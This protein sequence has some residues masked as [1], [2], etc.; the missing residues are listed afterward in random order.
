MIG[1]PI[2]IHTTPPLSIRPFHQTPISPP[3]IAIFGAAAY[4]GG[5]TGPGWPRSPGSPLAPGGPVSPFGPSRPIGPGKPGYPRP[6][7]G[8]CKEGMMLKKCVHASRCETIRKGYDRTV[9]R[10][11]E[12]REG[13]EGLVVEWLFHR[14]NRRIRMT[15]GNEESAH[16]YAVWEITSHTTPRKKMLSKFAQGDVWE[17]TQPQTYTVDKGRIVEDTTPSTT[18]TRRTLEGTVGRVHD[19][20]R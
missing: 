18:A 16:E 6:P 8:P 9:Y 10:L 17:K 14:E 1:P 13:Q 4:P 11:P 20:L 2:S 12:V 15:W 7:L 19:G 5:P 3:P